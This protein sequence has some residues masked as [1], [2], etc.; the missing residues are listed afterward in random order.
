MIDRAFFKRILGP[1]QD[2]MRRQADQY[3]K[4]PS[5]CSLMTDKESS[6]GSDNENESHS[7]S[8]KEI[9]AKSVKS[10]KSEKQEKD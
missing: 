9:T 4:I 3:D 6:S 7:D 5:D 10:V 2:I 1:L 8:S